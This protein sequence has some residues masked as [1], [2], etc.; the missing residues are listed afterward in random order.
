VAGDTTLGRDIGTAGS[1]STAVRISRIQDNNSIAP[2]EVS[3]NAGA[4]RSRFIL[5]P[6]LN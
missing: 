1:A 6:L 3:R 5:D 2:A 4:P